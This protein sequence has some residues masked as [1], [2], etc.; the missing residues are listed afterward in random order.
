MSMT[1]AA[2]P[3]QTAKQWNASRSGEV[4]P[5]IPGVAYTDLITVNLEQ[6]I[7]ALEKELKDVRA[8]V[9]ALVGILHNG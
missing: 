5:L 2:G 8:T 1:I 7:A 3:P 9:A 4:G 6:R